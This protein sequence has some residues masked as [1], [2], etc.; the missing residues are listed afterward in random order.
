MCRKGARKRDSYA[1]S[2]SLCALPLESRDRDEI[3]CECANC[4]SACLIFALLNDISVAD[5]RG[6][7]IQMINNNKIITLKSVLRWG[8]GIFVCVEL[9][10]TINLIR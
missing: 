6:S 9:E 4:F 1:F 3:W 10:T 7:N 5:R 2:L 8:R